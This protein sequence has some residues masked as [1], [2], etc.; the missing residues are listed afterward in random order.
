[1]KGKTSRQIQAENTK[2]HILAV[3]TDLL[4]HKTMDEISIQE[5]CKKSDVSVGA[6]Y[7]HFANKSGIIIELYKV[8]DT[9]FEN[10]IYPT[11]IEE[12]PIESI[13][14]YLEYQCSIP[15][16]RGLDLVKNTYKA[17][18]EYGNEFYLSKH[19]GLPHGLYLLVERAI[20]MGVLRK[21]VS[22]EQLMSELLIISRGII[23]N[24]CVSDGKADI[25]TDVRRMATNYLKSFIQ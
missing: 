7:H 4:A 2:A 25:L 24:W 1:M 11:L 22:A 19:R 12:E 10:E 21:N 9:Q 13:L 17:Q 5:I 3:A 14:K 15:A 18:I 23:Y 16:K 6:F 8:I 20:E